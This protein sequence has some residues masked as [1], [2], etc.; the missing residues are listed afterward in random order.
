MAHGFCSGKNHNFPSWNALDLSLEGLCPGFA[1][2]SKDIRCRITG[3]NCVLVTIG[4]Y[5]K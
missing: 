5:R 4:I 1:L 3:Q 2:A